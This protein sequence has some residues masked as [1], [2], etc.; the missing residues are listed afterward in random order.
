MDEIYNTNFKGTN[1]LVY[2]AAKFVCNSV[3]PRG[4]G[5]ATSST[6][7]WKGLS[8]KLSVFCREP[9][10]LIALREGQL[11]SVKIVA[12]L[13]R[14]FKLTESDV[15]TAIEVL[16]QKVS[17]V[18]HNICRYDNH[19]L[20]YHQNQVFRIDPRQVFHPKA[21]NIQYRCP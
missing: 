5:S 2:A 10:Q 4:H 12:Y 11:L 21:T 8:N 17:V 18:T 15:N 6:P 3:G 14:K 1:R 13:T 19:Y 16:K 20:Q 9:I 7:P